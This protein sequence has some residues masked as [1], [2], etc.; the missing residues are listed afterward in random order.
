MKL[1]LLIILLVQEIIFCQPAKFNK[2]HLFE[3]TSLNEKQLIYKNAGVKT[4]T[5]WVTENGKNIK[6]E[7]KL[8]DKSGRIISHITFTDE[9][10]RLAEYTY[11]YNDAGKLAESTELYYS[12]N[13]PAETTIFKYIYDVKNRIIEADWGKKDKIFK[14]EYVYNDTENSVILTEFDK[15][16]TYFFN[17]AGFLIYKT[18]NLKNFTVNFTGTD[19]IIYSKNKI[20]Q[21]SYENGKPVMWS[22]IIYDDRNNITEEKN[23]TGDDKE[24]VL[25]HAEYNQS[26]WLTKE[27]H[28]D[29]QGLEISRFEREYDKFG[30]LTKED[31][32]SDKKFMNRKIYSYDEHGLLLQSADGGKDADFSNAK[33]FST[34]EYY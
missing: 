3:D 32:Y 12:H 1:T 21:I 18:T 24:A 10:N 22:K 16:Q 26:G 5:D 9:N 2:D 8:F 20:E 28:N 29:E 6:K 15:S 13:I 25:Y 11:K 14:I 30:N 17:N 4:E 27:F 19:S 34:Y 33:Y 7:E 31:Y 23:K